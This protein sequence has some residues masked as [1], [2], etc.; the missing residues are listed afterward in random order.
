[1]PAAIAPRFLLFFCLTSFCQ[2]CSFAVSLCL[3]DSA[4][5]E[6]ALSGAVFLNDVHREW[7]IALTSLLCKG[8]Q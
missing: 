1:M 4:I 2:S 7:Q 6:I 5:H 8:F 3:N